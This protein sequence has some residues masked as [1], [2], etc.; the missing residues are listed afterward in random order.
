MA[1][2]YTEDDQPPDGYPGFDPVH[3]NH[4][5]YWSWRSMRRRCL[6]PSYDAYKN[7][8]GR[9]ITI[10]PEWSDFMVF[11]RDM[12]ER[13]AGTTLDR[14]DNNGHYRPSNCRWATLLQQHRNTRAIKL[15]AVK[16]KQIRKLVARGHLHRNVALEFGISGPM[17]HRV[18]SN[19]AWHPSSL[20]R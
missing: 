10:C 17:V 2:Q 14:I 7:Y 3:R 4:S 1:F 9:G 13:P 15:S 5:A 11:L 20:A 6:I 16:A 8:G 12:G 19:K 18:V